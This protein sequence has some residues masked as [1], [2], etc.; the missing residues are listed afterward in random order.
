[1]AILKDKNCKSPMTKISQTTNPR[2]MVGKMPK[3][4]RKRKRKSTSVYRTLPCLHNIHWIP[5][6]MI[7]W[8]KSIGTFPF[9]RRKTKNLHLATGQLLARK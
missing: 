3:K 1:M 9:Q 8:G 6:P 7:L 2:H 4:E 5:C